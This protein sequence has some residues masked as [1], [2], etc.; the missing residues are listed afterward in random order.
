MEPMRLTSLATLAVL[1]SV[2]VGCSKANEP[3]TPQASNEPPPVEPSNPPTE[4]APGPQEVQN[5]PS[6]VKD[7]PLPTHMNCELD[8]ATESKIRDLEAQL[9][10]LRVQYTD[11]HPRVVALK[12][13]IGRMKEDA[14]SKCVRQPSETV[15]PAT[16]AATPSDDEL[17]ANC[18]WPE[19]LMKQ[20]KLHYIAL[21]GLRGQMNVEH[22]DRHADMIAIQQH[23]DDLI[24]QA[25][26]ECVER[27]KFERAIKSPH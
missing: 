13:A 12:E 25:L 19:D 1:L 21:E 22:T 4:V 24:K 7:D 6:S 20:A 11:K 26:N 8:A 14:L 17:R 15:E 3:L 27:A 9:V 5:A 16:L 2:T 18:D 23:L 10:A